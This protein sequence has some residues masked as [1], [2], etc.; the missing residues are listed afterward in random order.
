VIGDSRTG[1]IDRIDGPYY[2]FRL[3][4]KLRKTL[5]PWMPTIGLEGGRINLVPVDWVASA[6]DHIAHRPGS[7]GTRFI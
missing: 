4:K 1:E 5:P 6:L 2:F 7:I 3:I